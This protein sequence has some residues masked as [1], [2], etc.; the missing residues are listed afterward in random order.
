MSNLVSY[1]NA[2]IDD[3][4][5]SLSILPESILT[6][7]GMS[8][9]K[10]R[11]LLSNI[12]TNLKSYIEI[13]SWK[14]ST[15]LSAAYNKLDLEMV[16]IDNWSEFGGPK[17][18]FQ[19][20]MWEYRNNLTSCFTVIEEDFHKIDCLP[21]NHFQCLFYDGAHDK[22][23]QIDA[24]T[25]MSQF[26]ADEFIFIV[27]DYSWQPVREGSMEGIKSS[28]LETVWST[29]LP[30]TKTNDPDNYWNGVL[31]SVLRKNSPQPS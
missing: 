10:C 7:E 2:A 22:Q 1:C 28:S 23:Y 16:A 29:E 4:N 14:G 26:M 31:V 5:K 15:T 8:S 19:S 11:H 12:T 9:R 17:L 18:D 20:N 27:D 24:I 30:T 25:H 3:S 21:K 13:G 6:M